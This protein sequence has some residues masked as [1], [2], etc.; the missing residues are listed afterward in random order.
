M[1]PAMT[2]R[3]MRLPASGSPAVQKSASP[4]S[5]KKKTAPKAACLT[6]TFCG[7]HSASLFGYQ[8]T[9]AA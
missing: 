7:Y 1:S 5:A 3:K 9:L 8:F 4:A 6:V 2:N